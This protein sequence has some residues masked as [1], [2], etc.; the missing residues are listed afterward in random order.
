MEKI[1]PEKRNE[2]EPPLLTR[3]EAL[4]LL[5]RVAPESFVL[6]T[7]TPEVRDG[8]LFSFQISPIVDS[9]ILC[10]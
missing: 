4:A 1:A 2:P 6:K 10:L 3:D 7:A 8:V 9:N 5:R